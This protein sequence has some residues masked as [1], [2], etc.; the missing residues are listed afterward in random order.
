MLID[1]NA[2]WHFD[3]CLWCLECARTCYRVLKPVKCA[4]IVY[5]LVTWIGLPGDRHKLEG[6]RTCGAW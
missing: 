3:V 5:H 6:P 4:L 1:M 2:I